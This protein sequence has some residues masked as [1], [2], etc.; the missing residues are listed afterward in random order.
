MTVTGQTVKLAVDEYKLNEPVP[1]NLLQVPAEITR[2]ILKQKAQE[3][4]EDE[5]IEKERPH[6]KRGK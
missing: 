1:A 6:L 4:A 5:K 2:L 3:T